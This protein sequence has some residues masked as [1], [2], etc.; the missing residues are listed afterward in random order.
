MSEPLEHYIDKRVTLSA[1][2]DRLS[3]APN[4]PRKVALVQ[5]ATVTTPDGQVVDI[6]HTWLQ[7]AATLEGYDLEEGDRITCSV[8]VQT[9][10]KEGQRRFGFWFPT[11]VK[12][13]SRPVAFRIPS[14]TE[15]EVHDNPSTDIAVDVPQSHPVMPTEPLSPVAAIREAKALAAKLGGMDRLRELIQE[16]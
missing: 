3:P 8:R 16:L 12:K 11:E 1:A 6:G 7:D 15:P 4:K 9:Y 14:L 5:D 2:F 10:E 13:M